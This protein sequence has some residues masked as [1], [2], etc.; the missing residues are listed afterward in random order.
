MGEVQLPVLTGIADE[1]AFDPRGGIITIVCQDAAGQDHTLQLNKTVAVALF[2]KLVML[3]NVAR[4]ELPGDAVDALAK[5]LTT[6][7]HG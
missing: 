2:G 5:M 3:A 4:F 6:A 7:K 1:M